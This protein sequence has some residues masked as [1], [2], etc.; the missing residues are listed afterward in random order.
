MESNKIR[1]TF[2]DFFRS[3]GHEIVPSA[4]IINKDDPTLLFANSGMNQFKD[5][6]TGAKPAIFPRVADTQKC[7]RVSGKHNDLEEV[8]HD[9]YHHTMFEMLGNWSFG[10][11]FRTEAI[12]W[13]WELLTEV[14]KIDKDKLYVT[15][16]GG[17]ELLGLPPD[18][19]SY[20]E[21]KKWVPENRIL[22]YSKEFNFWEMGETGP[23][24]PCTE[25][26]IDLR[27]DEEKAEL[28]GALVVNTG[29]FHVIEIWNIVLMQYF[30]KADGTLEGLKIK[31]VDTGMGFERLCMV[32]Q[33]VKSNY[34]T[35]CFTELL[36]YLETEHGAKYQR[37]EPESIAMRVIVDHIRAISFAIADGQLPSNTGAGYVIRRL[38]RR[39]SRYGFKYLQ[40]KVPF[41]FEMVQVLE[42]KL[43]TVFPELTKQCSFIRK[44]VEQEEKSFILKMERGCNMFDEYV[45]SLD[46]TSAENQGVISGKFAFELYDTFG[47]PVDLTDAMAKEK[48]L[49]VDINDFEANM[50]L[51]KER[52]KS[53]SKVETGDWIEVTDG[54]ESHFIGYDQ[55]TS[56]SNIIRYRTVKTKK[57]EAH[58]LILDITPF[59]AESGGQTGDTG[60]I[61]ND[62]E[63]INVIN[64]IKENDTIVH[65]VDQLPKDPWNEWKTSVDSQRRRKIKANHSATH[66]LQ[67]ALR[68]VLGTHVEQRGSLV[69][70]EILRFDFSHF[71]KMSPEEISEVEDL[72]N[73]K[74]VDGIPLIEFRNVSIEKA[75]NMG[76]MA[77][78]GEKYGETVRVIQFDP[79]FSV[80]LC[81]GTHVS[82]TLE[83]RYFKIIS[84]SS[85]AAGIRRIEAVTSDNAIGY[86]E[87]NGLKLQRIKSTLKNPQ[88]IEKAAIEL[89]EKN[90]SLEILLEKYKADYLLR[91]RD[92]LLNK[93]I[94]T[95]EGVSLI[96]QKVNVDIADDLKQLSFELRK[97]VT[98]TI[99]VLG[100]I[101]GDKPMLSIIFSDDLRESNFDAKV[102]INEFAKEIQGG[103]GGQK[104]Y[105]T[106]GGKKIEGLDLSLK[107]AHQ[108]FKI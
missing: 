1:N 94:P 40:I 70:D 16:F 79:E 96:I 30:R 39:A 11:Y 55:L 57:G 22:R 104:F 98:N 38:I 108:Y 13:G 34:D 3:K 24:G 72:V 86:L 68:K 71:D 90:K 47:F 17:D 48:G 59:Y 77:L 43:G 82:N 28:D 63:T 64:V 84:E 42:K 29:H 91:Q 9:T 73:N 52:S 61:Y 53:A 95:K 76:A 33:G 66:L 6:F 50:K 93:S 32:I 4:P 58:H 25:I 5:I 100:A 102:L 51:Q 27:T 105:A 19:E 106:A 10:D 65:L 103:G 81:G 46:M 21:W 101:L 99:I 78:F 85:I 97:M 62:H 37:S 74:I 41:M 12:A 7:L 87:E 36:H 80:E 31:S 88:D 8:G 35:D 60:I 14:F 18:N 92:E 83:I 54:V 56:S 49:T 23:C 75:Q 69:N 107:K 2:L 26:H 67:A 89:V 15:V 44:V 20:E 45:K